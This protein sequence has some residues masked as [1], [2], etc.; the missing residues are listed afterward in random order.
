MKRIKITRSLTAKTI[1]FVILMAT[2][3][4]TSAQD[5]DAAKLDELLSY[6]EGRNE[7]MGSLTISKGGNILYSRA[8][9]Y[10]FISEKQKIPAD[11]HTKYHIWSVTKMYTAAMILQ[12]AEEGKLKLENTLDLFFPGV[13]N[14]HTITI[15]DMLSHKSGIHDFTDAG[16]GAPATPKEQTPAEMLQLISGFKPDFEPG[17]KFQYSNSNYLLLGYIIERLDGVPYSTA[18]NNRIASRTG[19][20]DTYFGRALDTVENKSLSY[21]Y[22][23]DHWME[24]QEGDFSGL[25]PGGAG[26][27]VSTPSDMTRF[28][29]G[30]FTGQLISKNSLALMTGITGFYGLG[31][32]LV[33]DQ[34]SK[35]FGHGGGYIASHANLAY[36]PKDSL[37]IAFCTNGNS[38]GIDKIVNHVLQIC[39][40]TSYVLPFKRPAITVSENILRTYTGTYETSRF[41]IMIVFENGHLTA[42]P[43]DQP[44]SIL[45]AETE[46]RFFLRDID[47]AVEFIP[48][49]AG[50]VGKLYIFQGERKMEGKRVD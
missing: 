21:Q 44:K 43:V 15:R 36:Y 11:V 46:K 35:G 50:K 4:I 13:A 30:L 34:W 31:I 16:E 49:E 10:R 26:S 3:S 23:K 14:A 42:Q 5:P 2:C 25:V 29:H 12:L 24:V 40:D 7:A 38:Y 37:A 19:L 27:I 48:D 47:I 8:T 20:S 18:L 45:Y 17:D 1:A 39:Y 9:G 32:H 33:P 6:L 41:R 28:V 22:D